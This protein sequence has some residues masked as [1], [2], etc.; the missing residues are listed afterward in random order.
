MLN[1]IRNIKGQSLIGV[2]T[3]SA[4]GL[5]VIA[6]MMKAITHFSD[7]TKMVNASKTISDIKTSA[8]NL[9]R[10]TRAWEAT[11][12]FYETKGAT[13]TSNAGCTYDAVDNCC[14]PGESGCDINLFYNES[15]PPDFATY[16]GSLKQ[17]VCEGSAFFKVT[18]EVV[19]IPVATCDSAGAAG[20]EAAL[21]SAGHM[22][23]GEYMVVKFSTPNPAAS[24]NGA[25]I[26]DFPLKIED[27]AITKS[28]SETT[29]YNAGSGN[30]FDCT[31]VSGN[32]GGG[33][34][35]A[36]ANCAAG[37]IRTGGGA[38]CTNGSIDSSV[39]SGVNGW[40]SRCDSA[41]T[42]N[43]VQVHCCRLQ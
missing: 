43:T 39:T 5:I 8:A 24:D 11:K 29:V 13:Y 30:L 1:R 37:Y 38:D 18:G 20:I 10:N 12:K 19:H 34:C 7:Q 22:E 17:W 15:N 28:I 31:V 40:S 16:Y 14:Y 9:I 6:G 21:I 3:A 35:T 32:C 41:A 2:M 33:S 23:T 27:K 36:T 42:S 25:K 4:V 26:P